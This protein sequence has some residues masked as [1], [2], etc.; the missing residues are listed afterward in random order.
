MEAT[1]LMDI[2]NNGDGMIPV[3]LALAIAYEFSCED[4]VKAIKPM[5]KRTVESEKDL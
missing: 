2:T 3:R 4:V 1:T 5:K